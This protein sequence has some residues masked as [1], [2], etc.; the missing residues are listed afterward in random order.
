MKQDLK[1]DAFD[2][3][4][5]IRSLDDVYEKY[6][7]SFGL[8]YSTLYILHLVSLRENCTQKE[9]CELMYLP[10]QTVHSM[11]HLFLERGLMEMRA[12]PQDRRQKTLHLTEKGKA[13]AAGILPKIEEAETQSMAQF[14]ADERALLLRLMKRYAEVFEKEL[15]G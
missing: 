1:K 12:L 2:F 7:K 5:M 3:Y 8:S 6:A 11:I 15:L 10:K 4:E 13:Y 9:L 14:H